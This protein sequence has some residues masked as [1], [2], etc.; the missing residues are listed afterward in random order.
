[1][2][3]VN[4][5]AAP[6]SIRPLNREVA[7]PLTSSSLDILGQPDD[8]ALSE[9]MFAAALLALA[10]G[11]QSFA[12][13]LARDATRAED[14]VQE[15]MLKAWQ[16]RQSFTPGT[17]M[18]AWTSTILRNT[19]LSSVRRRRWDGDWTEKLE[20]S[21]EDEE[22]QTWSVELKQMAA[23]M[24]RLSINQRIA[25]ELVAVEQLSYE[26][27]AERV[28]VAL[29][30]IKSRVTRARAALVRMS[31]DKPQPLRSSSAVSYVHL[32]KDALKA[33]CEAAAAPNRSSSLAQ[34]RAA[35]AAGQSF[36]I[37]TKDAR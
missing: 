12:M 17:N 35:R 16:A 18:R 2:K 14:L 19:H 6:Y 23:L 24:Q 22:R 28:S 31:D 11:L 30:T 37:G 21:L 36:L 5:P 25:L 1:M 10:P 34:W 3:P 7:H 15:T 13:R 26:E 20:L 8:P 33:N 27:A 4:S 29:G 9:R 32:P